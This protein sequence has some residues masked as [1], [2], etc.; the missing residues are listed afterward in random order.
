MDTDEDHE[1]HSPDD[2]PTAESRRAT[3]AVE[4]ARLQA[5][6]WSDRHQR[7]VGIGG[8]VASYSADRISLGKPIRKPF[9]WQDGLWLTVQVN[10]G[11]NTALAY[12]LVAPE[13]FSSEQLSLKAKVADGRERPRTDPNGF[14]HGVGV[15]RAGRN[16]VLRGPPARFVASRPRQLGLFEG[17]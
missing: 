16:W 9:E 10:Y 15:F 3:Y 5:G 14:Y 8:I 2:R 17:E 7:F 13:T 12:R 11:S 1:E 4:P 6:P